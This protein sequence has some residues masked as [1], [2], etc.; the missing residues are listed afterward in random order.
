M[1]VGLLLLAL[2]LVALFLT[3]LGPE[4]LAIDRYPV[5]SW[6]T[7]VYVTAS[8]LG[9]F[10]FFLGILCWAVG[11]IVFA[12]SFLPGSEKDARDR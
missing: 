9:P 10:C 4:L 8:Q 6:R 1:R 2:S 7:S 11:Y 3:S 12:L 5:E